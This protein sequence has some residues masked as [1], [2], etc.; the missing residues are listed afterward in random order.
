MKSDP[1]DAEVICDLAVDGK[2]VTFSL[3]DGAYAELKALVV[4]R[5]QLVRRKTALK[6]QVR[7]LLRVVF[8]EFQRVMGTWGVFTK[9]GLQLIERFPTPCSYATT[10]EKQLGLL[11]RRWSQGRL[12]RERAQALLSAARESVGVDAGLHSRTWVLR[13]AARAVRKLELEIGA[14]EARMARW[15]EKVSYGICLLS[16]PGVG[17][18]TAATL[19]GECGD[20][21]DYPS[22][23]E[24]LKFCGL[25][26][27]SSSSG[28]YQGRNRISKRGSRLARHQLYL[29]AGRL[30][31]WD[32]AWREDYDRLRGRGAEKK[33]ALV[34]LS[35]RA[36]RV[37]FALARDRASYAGR[38]SRGELRH[39]A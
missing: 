2:W 26:L 38:G 30:A 16:M 31:R 35:R 34:A 24:L 23:R 22:T 21:D 12:G 20:L 17:V 25:N 4:H 14:V 32:G 36:V 37:L 13:R 29:L 33:E 7:A 11:L 5:E 10:D 28:Q 27:V 3:R 19:L 6:N 15:L 39:A 18:V 1:K 9:S 8:P